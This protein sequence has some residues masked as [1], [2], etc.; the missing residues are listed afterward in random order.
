MKRECYSGLKTRINGVVENGFSN[1]NKKYN[2]PGV[3]ETH[4]SKTEAW[5][6]KPSWLQICGSKK[7]LQIF[8]KH[9]RLFLNKYSEFFF[10]FFCILIDNS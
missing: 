10:H 4:Q 6:H 5:P 2:Y 8:L 1:L 9:F 3:P 7:H